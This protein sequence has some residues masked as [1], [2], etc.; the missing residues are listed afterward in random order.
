MK[1][2]RLRLGIIFNFDSRWMGGVIYIVNIINTLNFLDDEEK[3]EIILFYR[4]DLARFLDEMQYPYL[5]VIEWVF[6]PMI[7]GS[8]KSML[9]GKNLFIDEILKKFPL[10]TVYPLQDY[11]VRT[12]TTTKL[13][14]W[15]ADFQHRHYP[16][17]FSKT[18][19]AGRNIRTR[20]ALKNNDDLVLSSNDACSD[21]KRFF[22]VRDNLKIHIFRFVSVI[23]N[24]DRLDINNLK[25]KYKLPDNYFL[26]SN[27]FHKHKNHRVI[28]Q[29]LSL[30]KKMG[31]KRHMAMTG[32]LPDASE[33]PYLTELHSLI[34]DNDLND[35]VTML[36]VIPRPDQLKL[37]QYSQAVI[38]PSLFEGWSTVIEDA[39]SLQV[40][41]IASNLK[42]NIEQLGE[43]GVY[44]DP[45]KSDEL[46]S[47][48]L[49]YPKRNLNDV[50]YEDY[51]S[52]IKAAAQT[53]LEILKPVS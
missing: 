9:L 10:D 17:F 24:I 18:Q 44:F 26:I 49:N 39:K 15:C 31:I 2:S 3:P 33:S 20:L 45:H 35:Q 53:L 40:P 11:P 23:E 29:S 38:Q 5:K 13:V 37:M 19:I 1:K 43:K 28:L 12:R 27:Q 4:A 41:V 34:K 25:T 22:R 6:P 14:S 8:I 32:K 42:V 21:L 30:L 46:A 47:I 50:F 7:K 52:R 48:L 36:G 51:P 16:E